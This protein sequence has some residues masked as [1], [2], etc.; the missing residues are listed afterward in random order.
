MESLA[1]PGNR[2]DGPSKCQPRARSEQKQAYRFASIRQ[3]PELTTLT[4][5]ITAFCKGVLV[6]ALLI[7]L[8]RGKGQWMFLVMHTKSR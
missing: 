1:K 3:L 4:V 7:D 8:M 5:V 6:E 2:V